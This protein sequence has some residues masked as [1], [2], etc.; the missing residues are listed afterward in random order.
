MSSVQPSSAPVPSRKRVQNDVPSDGPPAKINKV[1]PFF[2]KP[3]TEVQ[4]F[5][6]LRPSLGPKRTCLHGTNLSPESYTKVAAFDLD[7]TIIKSRVGL[8]YQPLRWDWWH[9]SVREKLKAL[10][11]SGYSIVF[12]SNQGLSQKKLD[13][14]KKKIPVFATALPDVPFRILAATAKDAYRKPMPGMWY[15]LERIFSEDAVEIDKDASFFVGDAAGRAGDFAGTDRKWSLNAGIPFFTPEE[16][17]RGEPARPYQ[18]M[19]FHVSSLPDLPLFSPTS[20]PIISEHHRAVPEIVLLV[21][22]P[23]SGKSSFFRRY[24]E[25]EGYVHVNQDTLKTRQK[26]VKAVENALKNKESCVVDNT[27]RDTETRRHYL[28]LAKKLNIPVRCFIFTASIELAWHNN[29]YRAYNRP[30]SLVANESQRDIVPYMAFTSFRDNYEEPQLGEGFSEIKRVN[31]TFEG[32]DECK[33][34]WRMWLQIDGK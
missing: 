15:E 6:W 30:S 34:R 22:Y 27:N 7:G 1:H 32:D 11:Q 2:E 26:C 18:L 33:N 21:G 29:L 10:Y 5:Q 31:W 8:E 28:A 17:F 14:W 9:P 13:D 24:F 20:S 4:A 25:S 19:G 3:P 23:S 12:I 16:Y